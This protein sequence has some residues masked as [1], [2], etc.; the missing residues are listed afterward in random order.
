MNGFNGIG[1]ELKKLYPNIEL[2][3]NYEKIDSMGGFDVYVRGIGPPAERDG[4]GRLML[5]SRGKEKRMPSAREIVDQVIILSFAY[6]TSV[7]MAEAQKIFMDKNRSIIP[8]PY[9]LMHNYPCGMPAEGAKKVVKKMN[10]EVN[11][12][13]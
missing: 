2:I 3:G 7:K 13:M 6:G 1:G 8:R 4:T 10:M 12:I 5:F 9:K 11:F